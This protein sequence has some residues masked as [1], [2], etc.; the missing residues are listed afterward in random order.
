MNFQIKFASKRSIKV[1]DAMKLAAPI[2]SM[3][4]DR[5][6][7]FMLG[8][9]EIKVRVYPQTIGGRWTDNFRPT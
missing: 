9:S 1:L 5:H 8:I 3:D 2:N 6:I 4:V 7:A